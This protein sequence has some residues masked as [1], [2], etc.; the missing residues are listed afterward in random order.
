MFEISSFFDT[1]DPFSMTRLLY[2]VE[3]ILFVMIQNINKVKFIK[4]NLFEI[5]PFFICSEYLL[6]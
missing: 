2:F 3:M 6:T 4:Q 5:V 1:I